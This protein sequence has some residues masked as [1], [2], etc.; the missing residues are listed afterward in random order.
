MKHLLFVLAFTAVISQ[1]WSQS[2]TLTAFVGKFQFSGFAVNGANVRGT[3]DQ[4]SDQTNQFFASGIA[5]DDVVWDNLARRYKVVAIVSS[6]LTQA[7]VDLSR[8]G[9]GTHIPSGVGFVSR[10]TPNVGLSLLSTANN[11]GISNQLEGRIHTH[12]MLL[13]DQ[14]LNSLA[15]P[16]V[17]KF[18]YNAGLGFWCYCTP[19]VTVTSSAQGVYSIS[20]PDTADVSSIQKN[21]ASAGTDYTV[22]GDIVLNVTWPGATGGTWNADF[23]SAVLPDVKLVDGAGTQREPGAVAVTV[24]HTSVTGG[25]SSTTVANL[26]GLGTPARIKLKF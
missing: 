23:L 12:N 4:F 19:G 20:I 16:V 24:S 17:E 11:I 25:S 5:V 9:G 22:G 3:L 15:T 26:N 8:I 10:E 13:I 6:N 14:F 18:P 2:N 21:F 1:T 7:V